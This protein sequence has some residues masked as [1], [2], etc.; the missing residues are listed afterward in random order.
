MIYIFNVL[1]HDLNAFNDLGLDNGRITQVLRF[2]TI[3]K[4]F[5]GKSKK[6]FLILETS[7]KLVTIYGYT[8]TTKN[9]R[10][11]IIRLI[12]SCISQL[13]F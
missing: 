6:V 8:L 5:Y 3:Q 11:S 12:I 1:F 2:I 4:Y 9:C 7:N 10:L 13:T